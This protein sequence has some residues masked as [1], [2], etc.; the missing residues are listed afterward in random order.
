MGNRGVVYSRTFRY[1]RAMEIYRQAP[2]LSPREQG[3]LLNLGLVYLKQDDCERAR[4]YFLRLHR[5]VAENSQAAN[6][7][8]TALRSLGRTDEAKVALQRGGELHATSLEARKKSL[9]DVNVVAA[10]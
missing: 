4:P 5:L 3:I 2:R 10:R 1:A 6:L 9:R 8:A 7:L